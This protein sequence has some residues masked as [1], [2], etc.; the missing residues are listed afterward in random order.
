MT[1]DIQRSHRESAEL[2]GLDPDKLTPAGR[3][4]VELTSALRAAVDDQ[5]GRITRGNAADIAKLVAAVDQLTAFMKE[6]PSSDRDVD[7]DDGDDPHARL[8]R[9]IDNWIAN[10]ET[11]KSERAAERTAQGLPALPDTLEAAH[12]EIE[13]LRQGNPAALRFWSEPDPTALPAHEGERVI[14]V[15]T[16][17]I[18]PPSEQTGGRNL[19]TRPQVGAD[20]PKP[21]VTIDGK[22]LPPGAQIVNGRIVPIPPQALSGDE[23]RRRQDAVNARRDIDHA[24]MNAPSRVSGEPLPSLGNE[25]WRG[26]TFRFE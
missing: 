19:R 14:D 18:T 4:K 3:L 5:L 24:I 17:A 26:H 25:S 20:D 8:M 11:E 12:A 13:R 7:G 21:P 22:A 2:L 16:S 9:I 10:H 15:P 23:T 6:S 1:D